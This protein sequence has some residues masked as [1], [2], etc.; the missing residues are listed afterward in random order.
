MQKINWASI[1]VAILLTAC[2]NSVIMTHSDRSQGST[3]ET[4]DTQTA[5]PNISPSL[6]I[7]A[8]V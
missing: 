6:T 3:D 7:P 2:T 8:K 4:T 5:E 1:P